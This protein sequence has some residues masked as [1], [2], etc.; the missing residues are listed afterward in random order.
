MRATMYLSV[1]NNM[2]SVSHLA[3]RTAFLAACRGLCINAT[4]MYSSVH[5]N[6]SESYKVEPAVKA[7]FLGDIDNDTVLRMWEMYR[8]QL[9]VHC[10][11]LDLKKGQK[12]HGCI[13]DWPYYKMYYKTLGHE[14]PITCSEY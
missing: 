13:C 10:V 2:V 6:N 14:K 9:G 5:K 8:D 7:K 12:Y 11:W 3:Y 1:E 4:P